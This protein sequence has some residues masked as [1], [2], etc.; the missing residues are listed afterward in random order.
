M[1][2]TIISACEAEGLSP[3]SSRE[4]FYRISSIDAAGGWQTIREKRVSWATPARAAMTGEQDEGAR[5]AVA[6][7]PGEQATLTNLFTDLQTLVMSPFLVGMG[8]LSDIFAGP[9]G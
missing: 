1:E 7:I 5:R 9:R 6:T 4:V 8:T 2:S 3:M